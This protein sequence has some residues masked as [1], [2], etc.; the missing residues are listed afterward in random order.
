[1]AVCMHLSSERRLA[2]T[3]Q[4]SLWF[5]V[6]VISELCIAKKN[7]IQRGD[8]NFFLSPLQ[9]LSQSPL[10]V[11]PKQNRCF[12]LMVELTLESFYEPE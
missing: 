7:G 2:V 5:L 10:P 9:L 11:A 12:Q 1:M 8:Q 6:A 4:A 3:V